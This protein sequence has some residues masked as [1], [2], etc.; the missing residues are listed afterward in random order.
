MGVWLGPRGLPKYK[1]PP[2][3]TYTGQYVFNQLPRA[4]GMVDWELAFLTSGT[5]V[6]NRVVDSIDVFL[7]GAGAKGQ[8]GYYDDATYNHHGGK[9]GNGGQVRNIAGV[10]VSAG[11]PYPIVVGS[12]STN[13]S[14]FGATATNG[15]G[16]TGSAGASS[17][18]NGTAGKVGVTAFN[19]TAQL[20]KPTYRYGASGG[21]G[22]CV[23]S[24]FV[25]KSAGGKGADG[26]GAGGAANSASDV[27]VGSAGVA[28]SGGGGGGGAASPNGPAY[29]AGGNGGSGIIII[30]NAR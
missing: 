25:V 8:T 17:S 20:Y 30:R 28:N 14:G 13:T 2:A 11:I 15:G 12:G 7:V 22:G 1:K 21:G 19:G 29:L 10:A 6:F 23:L 9:G 26:G 27:R 18:S 16:K 5:L 24:N 3:F 4:D